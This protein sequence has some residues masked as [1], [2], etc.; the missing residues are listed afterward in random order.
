MNLITLIPGMFKGFSEYMGNRQ[1]IKA[2]KSE[3]RDELRLL[4]LEDK[5]LGIR[6]SSEA[7]MQMDKGA[8]QRIAWAD[9][10]S[11]AVF[12]LPALL[13]FYPPALPHI[14]A[15]FV[16]LT[17]M[18]QWYQYA[19]GMMLVSVWGY[20]KLVTPIILTITKAYINKK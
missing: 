2:A 6:N 11:F 9:D 15:G 16:A 14:K 1:E 8:N 10:V 17:A 3:R 5:L 12:L 4:S 7:D 19:L 13:A 20:R 18:P